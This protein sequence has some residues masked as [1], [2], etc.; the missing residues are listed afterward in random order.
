VRYGTK[1]A[2]NFSQRVALV[3]THP[4]VGEI[5]TCSVDLS[6]SPPNMPYAM[7]VNITE[8]RC[9]NSVWAKFAEFTF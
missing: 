2:P 8:T 7:W 5:R 6:M 4:Q 3:L 9:Q 1:E